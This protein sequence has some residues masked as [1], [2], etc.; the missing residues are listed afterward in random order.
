[1]KRHHPRPIERRPAEREHSLV[2]CC[3]LLFHFTLWLI[4]PLLFGCSGE[5][6]L[7]R[8]IRK[9][10]VADA[11]RRIEQDAGLEGKDK[12]RRTPLLVA[13]QTGRLRT[14]Q[15]LADAGVDID[16]RDADGRTPLAAAS[17][18]GFPEVCRV[19]IENGADLEGR[20]AAG[21]TPLWLAASNG[22]AEVLH[23]LIENGADVNARNSKGATPLMAACLAAGAP[24]SAAD[25]NGLVAPSTLL[26]KGADVAAR[27]A[28]GAT[29]LH[30]VAKSKHTALADLLIKAGADVNAG[31]PQR[32]TPLQIAA[33]REK[34]EMALFLLDRG[35]VPSANAKRPFESAAAYRLV[36]ERCESRGEVTLSRQHY[37]NAAEQYE[38]AALQCDKQAAS[39][40]A[41]SSS[42]FG[43]EITQVFLA[44]LLGGLT[45]RVVYVHSAGDDWM[46][47]ASQG[48]KQRREAGEMRKNAVECR[49]KLGSDSPD[50]VGE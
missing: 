42:A 13:A 30:L 16:T 20:T 27:D 14:V 41:K 33:T 43:R 35:A 28:D 11:T 21:A 44:G 47:L 31:G 15:E 29:A 8:A 49:A 4:P 1:M 18:K 45:G 12:T 3:R 50:K 23:L 26:S 46:S 19:L 10:N 22:H 37:R 24:S 9:G 6:A 38:K 39:Y 40:A 36:A 48:R 17:S 2:R 5:P 34:K 32:L 7:H 25:E